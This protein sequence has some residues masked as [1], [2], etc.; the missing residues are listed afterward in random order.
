[1]CVLMFCHS[2]IDIN[3]NYCTPY[4]L[5]PG[6]GGY[7]GCA[8]CCTTGEY[9]QQLQKIVYLDHRAF[10]PEVDLLR[11]D[12]D[13]SWP[14]EYVPPI[15][16]PKTQAYIDWANGSYSAA[17]TNK[18]RT[19]LAR[20]TGCKGPYSLR[21]LPHHDGY[22]STPVE[23]M[24]LLKNVA[25]HIVHTLNGIKDSLKVRRGTWSILKYLGSNWK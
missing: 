3:S 22:L 5:T 12:S 25:E 19:K 21:R 1:M 7:S 23:P 14:Q 2:A 8:Y 20:E 16:K 4:C 18:E 6:S 24:H 13:G 10:L 15:P 11:H 9:S 17:V